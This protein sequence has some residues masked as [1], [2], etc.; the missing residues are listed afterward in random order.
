LLTLQLAKEP[1]LVFVWLLAAF[2]SDTPEKGCTDSSRPWPSRPRPLP[3]A[4]KGASAM[5][6][7]PPAPPAPPADD[8][9]ALCSAAITDEGPVAGSGD[10]DAV[11]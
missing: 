7:A 6:P 9:D 10:A 5:E 4:A 3:A 2:T 8:C 1:K 11:A